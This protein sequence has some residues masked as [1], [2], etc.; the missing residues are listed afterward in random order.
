MPQRKLQRLSNYDYSK[1]GAYFITICTFYRQYLFGRIEDGKMV[2][3]DYGTIAQ[4]HL[5]NIQSHFPMTKLSAYIVMPNHVHLILLLS[6]ETEKLEREKEQFGDTT[7]RSRP[8]P[9]VSTV[10]GLYKSGVA[11][12]IHEMNPLISVWQKSFHDHIIRNEQEFQQ[13]REYI[14]ANN[15]NWRDDGLL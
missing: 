14:L 12:Q 15:L 6:K 13:I 8:F 1:C 5:L 9:T 7:E 3:N 2:L 11:K 4:A 10:V